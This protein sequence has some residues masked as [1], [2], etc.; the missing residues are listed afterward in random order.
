MLVVYI[1]TLLQTF[2]DSWDVPCIRKLNSW[3]TVYFATEVLHMIER[4]AS[5]V[6]WLY[7]NE[8]TLAD[9]RINIFFRFWLNLFEA[10]WIIYGSTFIYSEEVQDCEA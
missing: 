3:L 6:F 10:G 9:I 7:A 8:P 5:A 2:R 1:A 4:I